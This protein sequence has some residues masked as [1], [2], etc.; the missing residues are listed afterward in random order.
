MC[1]RLDNPVELI[2]RFGTFTRLY[3]MLLAAT[4][5]GLSLVIIF[6]AIFLAH[7]VDQIAQQ[8]GM[9][10]SIAG[11]VLLAGATSL[12]ELSVGYAAIAQQAADLTAG[13]VLGS[14]LVNLL[15]LALV[16][17]VF[18]QNA[19]SPAAKEHI[20]S[21]LIGALLTALI[22]VAMWLGWGQVIYRFGPFSLAVIVAYLLGARLVYNNQS[23]TPEANS[24]GN[25]E[26]NKDGDVKALDPLADETQ[27]SFWSLLK[28]IVGF[29]V[30]TAVIY[31]VAPVLAA[32]GD[33]IAEVTGL[34]RTFVGTLL[35]AGVTS[36][37]EAVSTITAV[38]IGAIGMAIGNIF[39]S[40]AFNMLIFAILDVA[41]PGSLMASVS[42]TH[43]FTAGC[44]LI[45]TTVAMMAVAY[46][47]K[48]RN[49]LLDPG[50]AWIVAVV[51]LGLYLVYLQG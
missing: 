48:R 46:Q 21:A 3:F 8:T 42:Q 43:V 24:D 45:A 14:S 47:P 19:F 32:K 49:W 6:A 7:F 16:D 2:Q 51:I 25:E 15:I 22:L 10:R 13:G 9:G 35:L 11:L 28:A 33:E 44:V 30:A 5:I 12:P 17:L 37:P 18:R 23:D 41:T 26:E 1:K 40:N 34:G 36:L 20:L 4:F 38:R 29:V 39:G 31:F 27:K 50:S